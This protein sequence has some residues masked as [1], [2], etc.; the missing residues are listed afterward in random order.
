MEILIWVILAVV[1]LLGI[2]GFFAVSKIEKNV[3]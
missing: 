2:F 1:I 3:S